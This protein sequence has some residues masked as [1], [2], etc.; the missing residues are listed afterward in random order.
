MWARIRIHEV[1]LF[2]L[3]AGLLIWDVTIYT[4]GDVS[5]PLLVFYA[6]LLGLPLVLRGDKRRRDG[7][8]PS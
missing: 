4:P 8:D 7:D 6:S 3:G 1:A 5:E 2:L